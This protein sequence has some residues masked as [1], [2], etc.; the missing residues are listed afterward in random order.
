MVRAWP[1]ELPPPRPAPWRS[2]VRTPPPDWYGCL[3][4]LVRWKRLPRPRSVTHSLWE[5][6]D[7]VVGPHAWS[8]HPLDETCS[9]EDREEVRLFSVKPGSGR[10][11]RVRLRRNAASTLGSKLCAPQVATR[12]ARGPWLSMGVVC[13]TRARSRNAM[14]SRRI[15]AR[16]RPASN[17]CLC[18][19][20][21][22]G[23]CVCCS[24]TKRAV[25]AAVS[26]QRFFH[27]SM[28]SYACN[29]G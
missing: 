14:A 28:F 24:L 9:P 19:S 8:V 2:L 18:G 26:D 6:R 22:F 10:T 11:G 20:D 3:I 12:M 23:S 4:A 16:L 17:S 5:R 29:H 27:F 1:S 25:R 21:I 13:C 7:P 15:G